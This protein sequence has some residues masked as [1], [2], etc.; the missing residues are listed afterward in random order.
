HPTLKILTY[1]AI[2]SKVHLRSWINVICVGRLGTIL[3]SLVNRHLIMYFTPFFLDLR[4]RHYDAH[5]K[6]LEEMA[7]KDDSELKGFLDEYDD[8]HHNL[9]KINDDD[10]TVMFSFDGA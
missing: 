5:H 1:D 9:D 2:K 3:C 10:F 8:M 7:S 4:F 6:V